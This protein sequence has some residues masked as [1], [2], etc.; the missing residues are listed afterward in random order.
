M[1]LK[2]ARSQKTKGMMSKSVVFMLDA[3]AEYSPEE[4]ANIKK[5]G[6]GNQTIYNSATSKAH[7]EKG[8]AALNSGTFGGVAGSM[9]S[10]AMAKLS[11]NVTI[12]SLGRGHHIETESLDELLGAEEAIMQGCQNAKM[13]LAAAAT[14][15]GAERVVEI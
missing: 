2:L 6:L 9:V 10:L 5:Y 15:D 11:L 3:R 12:D 4:T 13:Y 1:Q 7:L 14:F 8:R